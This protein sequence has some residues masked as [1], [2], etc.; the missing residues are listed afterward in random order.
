M[1]EKVLNLQIRIDQRTYLE[2]KKR[3]DDLASSVKV[4]FGKIPAGGGKRGAAT[5]KKSWAMETSERQLKDIA[6]RRNNSIREAERQKAK[7]DRER[8][9]KINNSSW[10]MKEA[11]FDK[12]EIEYWRKKELG[13]LT[14]TQYTMTFLS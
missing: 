1:L 9:K 7:A 13:Q 10:Y 6:K 5:E 11:G 3:I 14:D 2:A 4:A 12:K 8:I